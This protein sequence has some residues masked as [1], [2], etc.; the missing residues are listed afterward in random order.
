MQTL[1]QFQEYRKCPKKEKRFRINGT[2]PVH[3]GLVM[4]RYLIFPKKT[5]EAE[6]GKHRLQA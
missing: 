1:T 6:T 4:E 5:A 2:K 3:W